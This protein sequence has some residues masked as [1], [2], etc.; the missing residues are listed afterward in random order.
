[1]VASGFG[2]AGNMELIRT[3]AGQNGVLGYAT[4][5][6]GWGSVDTAIRVLN[7]EEPVVEGDGFHLWNPS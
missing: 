1:M 6:G 2:N 3:N 5:W 7:G 4:E